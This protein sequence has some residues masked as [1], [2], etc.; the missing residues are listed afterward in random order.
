M[1]G[2]KR[3]SK[4]GKSKA[5]KK[6]TKAK[7]AVRRLLEKPG[8]D[9]MAD[10]ANLAAIENLQPFSVSTTVLLLY[11]CCSV[12]FGCALFCYSKSTYSSTVVVP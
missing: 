8:P 5:H 6:N 12:S 1:F 10:V 9:R 2:R 11:C 3:S 7:K 4:G